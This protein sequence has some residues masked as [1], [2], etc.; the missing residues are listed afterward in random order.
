MRV[1]DW[2]SDVCSS[3]LIGEEALDLVRA[4]AGAR[5]AGKRDVGQ[6]GAAFGREPQPDERAIDLGV[7]CC[8][9]VTGRDTGPDRVGAPTLLE[10]AD[11]GDRGGEG[12]Q[13]G[14][15]TGRGRVWREV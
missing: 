12:R 2:S 11:A 3:D 5:Q 8:K 9:R 7:E 13:N 6:I 10:A 4:A 15:A 1:S 14:R